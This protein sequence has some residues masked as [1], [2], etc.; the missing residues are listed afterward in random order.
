MP[1]PLFIPPQHS[2]LIFI[3]IFVIFFFVE[4]IDVT[5]DDQL[6]PPKGMYST[7][8]KCVLLYLVFL[9]TH[10]RR[11]WTCVPVIVDL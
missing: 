2:R 1:F 4:L 8:H 3:Y 6:F 10:Q 11:E 9:F 7:V 5:N